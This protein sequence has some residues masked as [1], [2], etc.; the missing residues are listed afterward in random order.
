MA[1]PKGDLTASMAIL[2]LLIQ[3]PDTTSSLRAR[4]IREFP[5]G[6]WSRS[7]VHGDVPIL[8]RRGLICKVRAG[9]RSSEDVYEATLEG[10]DAFKQWV[11]EAAKAP[12]PIRD[13]ML[14]WLELSDESE[15]PEMLQAAREVEATVRAEY[16]AAQLRLNTERALG[17]FGPP[18]GSVWHGRMRHVVLS[19]LVQI[20]GSNMLLTKRLRQTLENEGRELHAA[21]AG[22]GDE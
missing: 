10:R 7:I 22:D 3:Q 18:D 19:Q 15:L 16:E 2:G 11:S 1:R 8:A 17:S 6:R 9:A 12:P 14:L 5:H 13:A 4:L 20:C 21:I